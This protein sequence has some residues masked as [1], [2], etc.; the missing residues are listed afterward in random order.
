MRKILH[1]DMNGFY[2]SVECFLH[3]ELRGR[4]VAV[5]G[6]PKSRHGI[7]LAKNEEAKKYNIKTGEVIWQA[8]LKCPDLLCVPASFDNYV[9]FSRMAKEIY[10]RY[11]PRVESFGLDECWLDVSHEK[12]AKATADEIRDVIKTELGITASVGVSFN[13]V[14]AKLGSDYKKPDATTEISTENYREIA[15]PLPAGDLL[16]VGRAT[17]AR[18][19]KRGIFTIGDIARADPLRLRSYLGKAGLTLSCF[20]RGEENSPV[21]FAT[22]KSRVKSVG[23]S[24]TSPRD[25]E[26]IQDVRIALYILAESVAARMR[27]LGVRGGVVKLY[28]RDCK[29]SHFSRQTTTPLTD[30]ACEIEKAAE[31]LFCENYDFERPVRSLGVS[32]SALNWDGAEQPTLFNMREREK[33]RR[34]E[35]AMQDIRERFGHDAIGRCCVMFDESLGHMSPKD[36]H[37]GVPSSFY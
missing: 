3:P 7:I 11:T 25:L 19:E 22:E 5:C 30:L 1:V 24:L 8:K 16:F 37:V 31:G 21:R 32:V 35:S 28:V 6:D 26:N 20:A 29:L 10:Q 23:N 12:D 4:P 33:A 18:L 36:D 14:F 9:K 15:W 34:L 27:H 13:K 2:A 17:R